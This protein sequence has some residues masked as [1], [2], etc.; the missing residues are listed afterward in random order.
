MPYSLRDLYIE[1][2]RDLYSAEQ[3]ILQALPAMVSGASSDRL[4]QAFEDHLE[5]TRLHADRLDLIFAQLGTTAA[6]VRCKGIEGLLE[7]G[8]ERMREDAPGDVR[9]AALI[10]AAQRVEH[11][12]IAGYGTARTFARLLGDW[13]GAKL[14]RQ[15][16]EEEGETDH[17]LTQL[18]ESG[19]NQSAADRER[20][21]E[22]QHWSRLRYVDAAAIDDD[23]IEYDDLAVKNSVGDGLGSLDGFVVEGD[24]GRPLYYV[25]DSG[26]WFVGR[27][28]LVPVGK[29]RLDEATRT[30]VIDLDK[31][32]IRK[33][34]EFSTN[35]F[36]SMNEDQLRGYERRLMARVNPEAARSTMYWQSYD[37]LPEYRQPAWMRSEVWTASVEPERPV[38]S[39]PAPETDLRE[40]RSSPPSPRVTDT[41]RQPDRELITAKSEEERRRDPRLNE[42]TEGVRGA[43]ESAPRRMDDDDM[44]R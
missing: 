19:I 32:Q 41:T 3:Q 15:T 44:A 9:D 6:G 34:P 43:T 20:G 23:L 1:E 16:A 33:H 40:T 21:A 17:R 26:G 8:R 22:T 24:T 36:L 25:V 10:S 18:A 35:A 14:L 29:G 2:L 28:Y 7:Q 11:Y 13:D 39:I 30:L 5:Q 31:D 27:R 12:E 38:G 37:E 42:M 4:K